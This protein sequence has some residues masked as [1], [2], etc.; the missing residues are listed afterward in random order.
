[1]TKK[2]ITISVFLGLMMMLGLVGVANADYNDVQ[3]SATTAIGF[4][5]LVVKPGS[6]VQQMVVDAS[7]VTVTLTPGSQVTFFSDAGNIMV[8][9]YPSAGVNVCDDS[10][11]ATLVV[12]Y[13]SD[14]PIV[15]LSLSGTICDTEGLPTI[16][17][18]V[19]TSATVVTVTM[20]ELIEYV[21]SGTGEAALLNASTGAK[22]AGVTPS[23]VSTIDGTSD[24][25]T[26]TFADLTVAAVRDDSTLTLPNG[27]LE[28][29]GSNHLANSASSV[30]TDLATI[31][32]LYDFVFA[33]QIGQNF[34]SIPYN[35]STSLTKSYTQGDAEISIQTIGDAG[36]DFVN[37]SS[38][39]PLYGYYINSDTAL[40]LRLNENTASAAPF[41]RTFSA[42]G[43]HLIGVASNFAKDSAGLHTD[44]D[45]LVTLG[46]EYDLVVDLSTIDGDVSSNGNL[47]DT[48]SKGS[49]DNPNSVYKA[50][51][52]AND[53]II[54]SY[55]LIR[56][57]DAATG[58]EFN[59]G[60]AYF[61]F[62]NTLNA[63]YA[64][65]SPD[66]DYLK[67]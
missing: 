40:Y 46:A 25:F 7:D 67:Y 20:S 26:F 5:D 62:T 45:L 64:G 27:I 57:E 66:D 43:W 41:D 22:F 47:D 36:G 24:S 21:N 10:G 44:D 17:T 51:Y 15:I 38:Y 35:A 63:K 55:T 4:S 3:F 12:S 34:M 11:D 14:H 37:A 33:V 52:D 6:R 59:H 9:N 1:M 53:I 18:V 13:D 2:L 19:V 23:A 28:D 61:I 16:S 50:L 30:V 54:S 56:D 8:L 58:I 29:T 60:E 65:A 32:Q 42:T 39:T 31:N 49:Y 48:H